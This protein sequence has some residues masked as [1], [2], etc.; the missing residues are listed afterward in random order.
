ME[1]V[2]PFSGWKKTETR[3]T[4]EPNPPS[5]LLY[6]TVRAT[7]S[8]LFIARRREHRKSA[9][10]PFLISPVSRYPGYPV[11]GFFRAPAD[12]PSRDT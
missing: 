12:R 8:G 11:I 6:N 7:S 4:K 5:R 2:R 3:Y 10:I 9:R 1:T